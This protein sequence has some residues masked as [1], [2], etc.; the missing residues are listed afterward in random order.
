M[1]LGYGVEEKSIKV[2]CRAK[3]IKGR[4]EWEWIYGELCLAGA[5]F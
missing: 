2:G 4:G 5:E 3:K 1:L